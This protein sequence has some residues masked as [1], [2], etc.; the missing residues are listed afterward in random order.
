MTDLNDVKLIGRITK[1]SVLERTA[2]VVY[3]KFAI[4]VNRDVKTP[5]GEWVSTP[6]FIDL[7]I[8]DNYAEKMYKFLRKG[9]QVLIQGSLRQRQ[10][11]KDDLKINTLGV[12]VN[13]VQLL[14]SSKAS[15]SSTENDINEPVEETSAGNTSIPVEEQLPFDMENEDPFDDKTQGIF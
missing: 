7:A 9:T 14:S 4:A 15:G 13:K 1:D 10:W 12:S 11:I 3:A 2:D 6:T 5:N 8:F